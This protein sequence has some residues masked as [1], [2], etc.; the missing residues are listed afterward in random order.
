MDGSENH[1]PLL[2][3]LTRES[4][5]SKFGRCM[6]Q[7]GIWSRRRARLVRCLKCA[8]KL[9]TVLEARADVFW[10]V[11]DRKN[12]HCYAD[13]ENRHQSACAHQI[14]TV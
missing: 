12:A 4:R 1:R 8:A 10:A 3:A 2:G 7:S 6:Q 9:S 14:I 5:N 11:S 13:S